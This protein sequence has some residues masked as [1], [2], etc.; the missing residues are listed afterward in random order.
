M[1]I[2]NRVDSYLYKDKVFT[3]HLLYLMPKLTNEVEKTKYIE[4]LASFLK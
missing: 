2:Q 4:T 1:S 3:D